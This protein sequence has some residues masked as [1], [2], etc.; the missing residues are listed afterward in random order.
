MSDTPIADDPETPEAD[1]G[2]QARTV[3]PAEP[4]VEPDLDIEASEADVLDQ[5][6][7]LVP[8]DEDDEHRNS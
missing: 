7:P 3:S 6:E 8:L 2:E 5:A 1:S 4:V